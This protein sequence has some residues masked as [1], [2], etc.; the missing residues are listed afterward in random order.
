M[1]LGHT[2]IG[3]AETP[4]AFYAGAVVPGVAAGV[5]VRAQPGADLALS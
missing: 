4:L 5:T 3:M 1:A 2:L